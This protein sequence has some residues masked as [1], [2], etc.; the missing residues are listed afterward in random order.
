MG[1]N[2]ISGVSHQFY[3]VIP[4]ELDLIT[5]TPTR[6]G[7]YKYLSQIGFDKFPEFILDILVKIEGHTAVDVTDG[8]GDEKQDILTI[9][10]KGERCLTQCKHTIHYN[11]HY[12]GN[13]LDLLVTA[14]LRKAC[15]QTIFVTNSDLTPQG[16]KYVN[17]REYTR[18]FPNP[19]DCP[20]I[21]YWNGYKIWEKIKNNTDIINKWFSGLGQVHGLRS[22]K[23]DLTIQK[24]PFV[25]D[26]EGDKDSFDEVLKLLNEKIWFIEVIEGLEYKAEISD[27]YNVKITKWFQF[28]GELDI[29]YSLPNNDISFLNKPLY[30]LTVEVNMNSNLE[31]YSPNEIRYEIV[32]KISNDVFQNN[33]DKNW[34]HLTSSQIRTIIYLHDISEPRE[35][36]LS[37]S[38]TYVKTYNNQIEKELTY[39]SLP[40]DEFSLQIKDEESIWIHNK[41]G[42][43][44]MQMFEQQMNPVDQYHHQLTQYGQLDQ[45]RSHNFYAI[46]NIDSSLLMRVRRILKYEWVAFQ[47]NES[48]LIWS[49]PQEY[50]LDEVNKI[51]KKLGSLN[52]KVLQVDPKD[53][54]FILKNIQKEITPS[55]WMYTSDLKTI[56]YPTLLDKRVFCL[57]KELSLKSPIDI[58]KALELLKY[59]YTIEQQFG[60]DNMEGKTSREF[61]SSELRELL[62]DF[63]TFRGSR[64]LD[65]GIY[66][67]PISIFARF[68]ED[69]LQ[70]SK[71]LTNIYINEFL[72]IYNNIDKI[73]SS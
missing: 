33:S 22:F 19:D 72:E 48:A 18:G 71:I 44:I 5:T 57:S 60:Y 67:E 63:F 10:P 49:V 56:T 30:A 3:H 69:N 70:S 2:I 28:T 11:T 64:M 53:I 39:C 41:T 12:N 24:L 34:W 8:Q 16:K 26:S 14:C 65:I 54:D 35:I 23:F 36:H 58:E 61:N 38:T 52:L 59:K 7:I 25:K 50:N 4:D 17:D 62:F 40:K 31:K 47:Y 37:H 6:E 66:N 32:N 27:N 29:N 15:K 68:K 46:D 45:I 42:V 1:N 20:A 55:I 43:Q 73:L 21:D 9:N 13:D 51:H